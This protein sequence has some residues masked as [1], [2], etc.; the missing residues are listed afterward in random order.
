MAN[1]MAL[2]VARDVHLPALR[3]LDEPPR[4]SDLEGVRVYASDQTHFSVARALDI[5][6]FPDGAPG[7][8]L[9]RPL[10]DGC[11]RRRCRRRAR[12]APRATC[13]LRSAPSPGRRTPAAWTMWWP[14]ARSR[15]PR[16]SGCTW[17][18]PTAPP[19]GSRRASA[20]RV[21]GLELADSVTVDPHKWFFQAYDIGALVVRRREDL[22]RTFHRAPEY[23]RSNRPEDEPLNWFQYS[24]EG[25]RSFRALKLW[26]SWQ[27]LG[28]RGLAWLGRARRGPRVALRRHDPRGGRPR[29]RVVTPNCPW[30]VSGTCP[31]AGNASP[32]RSWTPI[33]PGASV[34]WR[35]TAPRG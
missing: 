3:G 10:P 11:A 30:C 14:S 12:T 15:A 29:P 27:H 1:L 34:P 26:M 7:P 18:R 13:R 20:P 35:P 9:R 23:Y 32:R 16:D 33:R 24:I 2:T 22:R 6:G 4:G 31:R 17:T 28:T 19:R 5:L 21:P 8:A 25:T